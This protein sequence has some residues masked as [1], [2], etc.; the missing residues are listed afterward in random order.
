MVKK[1]SIRK[2]SRR[3]K[4]QK[5]LLGALVAL[6]IIIAALELTGTTHIFHKQPP[7]SGTNSVKSSLPPTSS[8]APEKQ[9]ATSSPSVGQG[10]ATDNQGQVSTPPTNSQQWTVSQSGVITVKQP[11]ANAAFKSGDTVS[12]SASVSQ[13]QYR[14][15]DNQIGVLAQGALTVVNGS[16]SGTMQ[17]KSV[18][19]TGRLDIFSLSDSGVETNEVEIPVNF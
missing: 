14:L 9:P 3:F 19:S 11:V 17:F 10:S 1:R 12:G 7:T 5:R 8:S 18:A 13:V 6:V 2:I 15:I 4:S 16:F